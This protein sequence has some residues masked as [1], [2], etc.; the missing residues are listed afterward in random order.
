MAEKN[1]TSLYQQVNES[2]KHVLDLTSRIDERVKMLIDQNS[3][4]SNKIDIMNKNYS[5][6]VQRITI[7]ESYIDD[8]KIQELEKRLVILE[9]QS[10]DIKGLIEKLS[11]FEDDHKE[12]KRFKKS[13][14]NN[15]KT[16]FD[17]IYK[18]ITMLIGA[19]LLWKFGWN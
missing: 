5:E 19:Y 18:I 8:D 3:I 7:L 17:A 15:L 9:L 4:F 12:L 11:T 1:D 10:N 16:V 2:M 13:A 6:M 14:E